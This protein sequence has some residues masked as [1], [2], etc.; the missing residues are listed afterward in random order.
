MN[1]GE[2]L[3]SI[4]KNRNFTLDKI[5]EKSNISRASLSEWENNKRKPT[6][7][8]LERWADAVGIEFW[9]IF[10]EPSSFSP[11][12]EEIDMIFLF[13]MLSLKDQE[14]LHALLKLM[15]KKQTN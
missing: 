2:R 5:H 13:R 11:N 8:A 15:A 9:D 12:S 6:V 10:F 3:R 1:L 14:H 7:R 4:R